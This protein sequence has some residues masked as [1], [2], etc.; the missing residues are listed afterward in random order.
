M[1]TQSAQDFCGDLLRQLLTNWQTA[2]SLTG[3]V[4]EGV[5]E[6]EGLI[7]PATAPIICAS[8]LEG[9]PDEEEIDTGALIKCGYLVQ[10]RFTQTDVAT[11]EK[12]HADLTESIKNYLQVHLRDNITIGTTTYTSPFARVDITNEFDKNPESAYFNNQKIEVIYTTLFLAR[13]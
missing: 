1:V 3:S 4:V 2:Q 11:A 7:S 13:S 5:I 8:N 9:Y 6:K 10:F 12:A